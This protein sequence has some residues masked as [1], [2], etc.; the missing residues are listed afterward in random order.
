[1]KLVKTILVVFL[2]T[3]FFSTNSFSEE[4][5]NQKKDAIKELIE[6]TGALNIGKQFSQMMVSQM[7]VMLKKSK[8]DVPEKAFDILK[9]VV[10]STIDEEM[11][12]FIELCYP[13]YHKYLT[14]DEIKKMIEFY[15]TPIG[16]KVVK[17]MP[18]MMQESMLAAQQ[19]AQ[20]IGIKFEKRFISRLKEEGIEIKK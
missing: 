2:C 7:T 8:S 10:D 16:K 18:E 20:S 1:M 15:K 6:V 11:S 13:I 4:L 17:V 12:S 3:I 5:S 14:L 9:E 19:W